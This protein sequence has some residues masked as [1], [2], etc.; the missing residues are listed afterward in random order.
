NSGQVL[1][2]NIGSSRRFNFTMIGDVVNVASRLE[3]V[4]KLYS[5]DIVVGDDVRRAVGSNFLF[6][7]ID[8]VR[9]AGREL[10]ITIWQ[11]VA[12]KSE[13]DLLYADGLSAWRAG[14]FFAAHVA[15]EAAA[16]GGD[17][18]A[19]VMASRAHGYC[20]VPPVSWSGVTELRVK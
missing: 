18:V 4:G 14:D 15:F 16:S 20:A 3:S 5:L 19:E 2:G 10:P 6:R 8:T 7:E 11:P 17:S 12:S 9:L 13:H 1:V